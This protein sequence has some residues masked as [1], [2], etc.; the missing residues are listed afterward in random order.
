MTTRELANALATR[1]V[2]F[3]PVVSLDADQAVADLV[4]RV[5]ADLGDFC[6]FEL[7]KREERMD[8]NGYSR[9][10]KLRFSTFV[11]SEEKDPVL[12]D[13]SLDCAPTGEPTVWDASSQTGRRALPGFGLPR[14]TCLSSADAHLV[15]FWLHDFMSKTN[16]SIEI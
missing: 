11:G 15:P 4:E 2:D 3:G 7:T 16:N 10:L 14:Y 1:D 5:S 8:E 13:P 12:I 9:L 6:R